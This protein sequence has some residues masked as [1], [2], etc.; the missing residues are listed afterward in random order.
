M[1]IKLINLLGTLQIW[2]MV[3]FEDRYKNCRLLDFV[4]FEDIYIYIYIYIYA[5]MKMNWLN[6]LVTSRNDRSINW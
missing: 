6:D 3:S 2:V 1:D 5:I 4:N